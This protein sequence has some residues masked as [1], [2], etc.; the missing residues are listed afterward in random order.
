MSKKLKKTGWA[1]AG[2]YGLYT[3]WWFTRKDAIWFHT[4]ALEKSWEDCKA[5]G[6]Y[7]VKIK[8]ETL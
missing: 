8:I 3:G 4:E 5:K 2:V 6:D 7:A 1:I